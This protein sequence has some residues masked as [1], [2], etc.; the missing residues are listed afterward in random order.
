M[1]LRELSVER[2]HHAHDERIVS[3]G[4]A[5]SGSCLLVEGMAMRSHRVGRSERV[6]SALHVAGDFVD[7]HAFLLR[8]LDHDIVAVGPCV[9][10]FVSTEDL[11]RITREHPH[12]ARLLWTDTLVD[13]KI[14]RMWVALRA[15]LLGHQRVGHLI[16]EL[17][18]R[19]SA[20]GLVR[21]GAFRLPLDQRGL[22]EVLG[23]SLVH[24]NRAIQELRVAG[25]LTWERG[26]VEV[27][28]LEGLVRFTGFDPRYLEFPPDDFA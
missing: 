23:Y 5:P 15:A 1:A 21:D 3:E 2:S 8:Y 25:Y 27:T 28:D 17:Y 12:L 6:I 13:A 9:V 18:A 14:H 16:C 22:A 26:L 10:E 19:L 20:V 7:L 4:P 24:V 11:A